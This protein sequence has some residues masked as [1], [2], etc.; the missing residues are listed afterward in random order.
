MKFVHQWVFKQIKKLLNKKDI[1]FEKLN[2]IRNIKKEGF[3]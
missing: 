1:F 2:I 3:A